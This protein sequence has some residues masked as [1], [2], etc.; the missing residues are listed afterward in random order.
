MLSKEHVN[1]AI[2]YVLIIGIFILAIIVIK[3]VAMSVL[4]GI[5]L[6]YVFFPVYRFLLKRI[7]NKNIAA[8]IVCV[9]VLILIAAAVFLILTS[10]FKQAVT[11]YL[12]L[13]EIDF[14]NLLNRVFPNFSESYPAIVGSVNSYISNFL[15]NVFNRFS[16]FVLN[17]P[18]MLL[19]L[20][21]V[22][23]T[24]FFCLRD[25]KRALEYLKSLAPFKKETMEKFS[26][27]FKDVTNSVLIGQ[28][29]VGV[30]QGLVAGVG[31]FIFGVPNAL[32]LMLLT[33]LIGIIPL[34]G[35]WLVWIPVDIYLFATGRYGSGIGLLIYGSILINWI[36]TVVRPLIVSKKTRINSAIVIVGMIGGLFAFGILGLIIGPLVLGYIL[37]IIEM[38]RQRPSR[39]SNIVFIKK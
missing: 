37:L 1:D 25:G 33:M 14:V 12:E 11:F 6:A 19:K 28:I 27:Q 20:F 22:I 34:I 10:L 29:V 7:K 38:Y 16:D 13:Q 3:P 2:T 39:F 17:L 9:G 32:I 26:K 36:D 4:L 8:L 24:F 30:L 21:V 5:L 31:Y 35:P 18:V 23:F 15:S